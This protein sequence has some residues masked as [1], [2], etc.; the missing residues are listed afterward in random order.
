MKNQVIILSFLILIVFL[1]GC[2][3]KTTGRIT[4]DV[5]DDKCQLEKD[6][7]IKNVNEL[8]IQS[9][10]ITSKIS[11]WKTVTQEDLELMKSLRDQVSVIKPPEGFEMAQDYYTR[12]FN[13][14]V[15]A[16]GYVM[17]AKGQY[18]S[19]SDPSSVQARNVAMTIV[20]NDIQEANKLLIYADEEV[21]FATRLVSKT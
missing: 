10:E 12:A 19:A 4:K 14:Y 6:N 15:E 17:K 21:K 8:L 2:Q 9:Q 11:E 1:A 7:Y 16:V 3:T 20:I 5:C 18:E 13:H